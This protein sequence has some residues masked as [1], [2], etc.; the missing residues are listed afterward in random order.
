LPWATTGKH[1]NYMAI[2]IHKRFDF[3]PYY[4]YYY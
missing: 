1:N 3:T 2:T 4:Y